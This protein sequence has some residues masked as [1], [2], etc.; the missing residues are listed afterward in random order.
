MC[1]DV[2]VLRRILEAIAAIGRIDTLE[3]QV[4]A[5]L[6]S[7]LAIALDLAVLALI[8]ITLSR[9]Q[10]APIYVCMR[11]GDNAYQASDMYRERRDLLLAQ[12]E[13]SSAFLLVSWTSPRL[14]SYCGRGCCCW[15][16]PIWLLATVAIWAMLFGSMLARA[17][18]SEQEERIPHGRD[19]DS[20]A[21]LE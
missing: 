12:C 2:I 20:E 13:P 21:S 15:C 1:R 16:C 19:L 5:A 17:W 3:V 11:K 10:S 9:R 8:A 14:S 18:S 7:R 4:P 6:A